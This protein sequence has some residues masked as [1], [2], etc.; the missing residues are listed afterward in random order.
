LQLSSAPTTIVAASDDESSI[1]EAASFLVD[2][3]WIGDVRHQL[4]PTDPKSVSESVR[5]KLLDEQIFEF[6]EKYG[7][8]LGKRL[9]DTCILEARGNDSQLL[10]LVTLEV[11]LVNEVAGLV[12]KPSD[13]EEIVKN[14]VASLRPKDRRTYKNASVSKITQ[15]LLPDYD[16]VCCLSNL[17]VSSKVRRQGL[18]TQLC[19]KAEDTA[20]L[21]WEFDRVVLKVESDN[22]AA[23]NLYEQKL[24]Y[25]PML[26]PAPATSV[27]RADVVAGRF[28]AVEAEALYL[29]KQLVQ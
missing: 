28:V 14:A 29:S 8:R 6:R 26:D 10:G 4:V 24:S 19:E 3:F 1:K 2:S 9:L 11:S 18:G 7:E 15:E 12:L 21:D 27:I 5:Q 22:E 13:A 20:G 23:R 16:L 25:A 17:A